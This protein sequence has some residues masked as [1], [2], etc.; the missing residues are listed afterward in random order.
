MSQNGLKHL[1]SKV[2]GAQLTETWV[3]PLEYTIEGYSQ[4][5]TG[6]ILFQVIDNQRC[7][8][9]LKTMSDDYYRLLDT[10]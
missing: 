1:P 3:F 6:K 7:P 10:R 9:G 5:L 2:G 4:T 8:R